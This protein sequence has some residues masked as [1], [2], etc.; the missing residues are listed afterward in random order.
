MKYYSEKLDKMFT[1]AKELEIAEV[2]YD[3]AHKAELKAK[4][5]KKVDAKKVEDAYK[6]YLS[7]CKKATQMVNEAEDEW[8]KARNE[9]IEKHGSYHMTYTNTDKGESIKVASIFDLFE[10]FFRQ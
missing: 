4:E 6:N 8:L 9:F 7:V 2:A 1:T 3:E 5:E 10:D